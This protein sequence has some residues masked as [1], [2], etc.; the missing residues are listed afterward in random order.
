MYISC[1]KSVILIFYILLFFW[2]FKCSCEHLNV[3]CFF[4]RQNGM[5]HINLKIFQ[6]LS[7]LSWQGWS[8]NKTLNF[9]VINCNA[10][11]YSIPINQ[12]H[13]CWT[14]TSQYFTY[15]RLVNFLSWQRL[16]E[17]R[18]GQIYYTLDPSHIIVWTRLKAGINPSI[19]FMVL[20][21]IT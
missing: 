20:L 2:Q 7:C 17:N 3:I 10:D 5:P 15:T 6:T 16:S 8:E 14:N 13:L 11:V 18:I 12:S 9:W 19:L 1:D 21:Y 4:F